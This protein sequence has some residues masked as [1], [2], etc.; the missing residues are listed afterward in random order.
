MTS[1]LAKPDLDA[2]FTRLSEVFGD[3]ISATAL[4][5]EHHA[6]DEGYHEAG[7]P[8]LV[9]WPASTAEVAEAVRLCAAAGCPVVPWGAGTSLEGNGLASDGGLC[10]DLSRMTGII[11]IRPE[12]L[13]ATVQA[14]VRREQLNT[15]LKG[16]GLY[17]PIDPGA[18]ATLGGMAATRAS[19]TNA[20]RYGT[21][22]GNVLSC[23]VVMADGGLMRTAQRA[24]KSSAGYD[25]TALMVGS[26]GTLGV[27]TELTV[28]LYPLPEEVVALVCP[29]EA[30][31]G[32]VQAVIAA[33]Q[34]GLGAGRIEFL[35]D[36]MMAAVNAYEKMRHAETPT[37]FVEFHGS[38]GSVAGQAARFEDFIG[39]FGG[40]VAQRAALP[41][42][43]TALWKARHNALYAARALR[44]GS[45]AVITDVC[46]P[47]SRLADCLLETR[48]D[49]D[50]SSLTATIVGHVGD[51]NFHCLILVD[52]A[53][54]AEVAEAEALH[55]AMAR[56]AIAMDGTC[57]GE[58]GVGLGKRELLV[59]EL[60]SAVATMAAIKA[61]LDPRGVFNPGKIL[62]PPR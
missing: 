9:A 57:T 26:E 61:A 8:D 7:G 30:I 44:P 62:L 6:H 45:R 55:Q 24:P 2:L 51:G 59:E 10:L 18:D 5:R 33:I 21:M 53:D 54:V 32:A 60:G 50:A 43:R 56:R 4:A 11:A 39:E 46:V 17:F 13:S 47:I 20:V 49:L 48:A 40:R 27:I 41:E 3:R 29:F 12:D 16:S 37:L 19:G 28:R 31:D 1:R 36:R 42:D 35:D 25:L 34:L 22:R 23:T 14:G 38:P 15:E 52:P 58:H